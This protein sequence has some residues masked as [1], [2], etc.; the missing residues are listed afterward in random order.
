[1]WDGDPNETYEVIPKEIFYIA[2]GDFKMGEIVNVRSLGKVAKVDF[3]AGAGLGMDVAT[4]DFTKTHEYTVPRFQK[5]VDGD[6]D[7]AEES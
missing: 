5:T 7:I 1:M 2:T 4:V 6:G 3:S